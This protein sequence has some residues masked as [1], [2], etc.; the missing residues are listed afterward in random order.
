MGERVGHKVLVTV[1]AFNEGEKL[2]AL[3]RRFPDQRDY[4]LLFIDDGSTDGTT[5]FLESTGRELIR[6]ERNLGVGAGIRNS[7][8]C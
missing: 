7:E 4:Q 2:K 3:V 6:H 5:V 8:G 1:L